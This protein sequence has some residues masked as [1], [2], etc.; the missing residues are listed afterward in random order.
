MASR[1]ILVCLLAAA[2]I[3][4]S[5]TAIDDGRVDSGPPY[6]GYPRVSAGAGKSCLLDAAGR[7]SCWGNILPISDII[8]DKVF[9]DVDVSTCD[10]VGT[11]RVAP[12]SASGTGDGRGRQARPSNART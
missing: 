11:A 5:R 9:A 12:R 8:P 7:L 6:S 4:C 10:R 2:G 3:A 1:T